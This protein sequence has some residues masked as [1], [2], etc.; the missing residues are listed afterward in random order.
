M[1]DE[2]PENA[3]DGGR[4]TV[5][6]QQER[7]VD[8]EPANLRVGERGEQQGQREPYEGHDEREGDAGHRAPQVRGVAEE[9]L[10]IAEADEDQSV[11]ERRG[12]IERQP[13]R[14]EGRPEEEDEG[15]GDLRRD[16]RVRQP[17]ITEDRALHG[18]CAAA[19]CRARRT[20]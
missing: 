19:I 7:A 13:Y 10:K 17:S 18:R 15:D 20:P 1:E 14:V 4:D 8:P 6:Q 12:S 2:K 9:S 5:R 3:G 11:A 16:E